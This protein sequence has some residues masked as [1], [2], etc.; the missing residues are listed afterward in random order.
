MNPYLQS[1]ALTHCTIAKNSYY[2]ITSGPI[3]LGNKS[4]A[5][6]SLG[7]GWLQGVKNFFVNYH[8]KSKKYL[9]YAVDTIAPP[10]PYTGQMSKRAKLYFW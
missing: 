5:Y 8:K 10:S 6:A 4:Q 1:F 9:P 2:K 7:I 3:N